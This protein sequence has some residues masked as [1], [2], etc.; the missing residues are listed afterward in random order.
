VSEMKE[1]HGRA[2]APKASCPKSN[3]SKGRQGQSSESK[4]ELREMDRNE[5]KR[6]SYRK[7]FKKN[8]GKNLFY[9]KFKYAI[10]TFS[11]FYDNKFTSLFPT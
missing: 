9:G 10:S 1:R 6:E 3:I 5:K 7:N 8:Q 11:R 2:R 4:K